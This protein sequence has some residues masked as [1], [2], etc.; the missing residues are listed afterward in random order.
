[1]QH[2]M[3]HYPHTDARYAQLDAEGRRCAGNSYRC[4][5]RA[6]EQHIV[7]RRD[8][9]TGEVTGEP[10]EKR[11]CGRHRQQFTNSA[12]WQPVSW[13]RMTGLAW[14]KAS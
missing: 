7:R 12:A 8:P 3:N 11:L 9:E 10:E 5:Q 14:P 6:I 4:T 13:Q 2:E 1:M